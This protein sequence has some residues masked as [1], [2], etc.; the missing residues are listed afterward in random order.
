MVEAGSGVVKSCC[1]TQPSFGLPPLQIFLKRLKKAS[2]KK[3]QPTFER[4][5]AARPVLKIDHI[6][7]ERYPSFTDAVRDLDDPLCMV[8]LFAMMPK[9]YKVQNK[10]V[11]LCQRLY[12]EF[13][14]YAI[15]TRA[16]EK[17]FLSIKGIYYQA[18]IG[19]QRIT[20]LAPYKFSMK[21]RQLRHCF[22]PF[23][24][25]SSLPHA[26]PPHAV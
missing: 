21:V 11:K 7:K 18:K 8:A 2:A 13:Q 9:A 23:P 4:L 3:Q 25:H 1:S 16:L 14:S 24:A 20:W 12:M 5:Q 17:V 19:G 15:R 26:T 22:G 6:I 10:T